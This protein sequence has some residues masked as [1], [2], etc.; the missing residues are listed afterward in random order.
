M[1]STAGAFFN[2]WFIHFKILLDVSSLKFYVS[3]QTVLSGDVY[4]NFTF[5]VDMMDVSLELL[6]RWK[7]TEPSS[8]LARWVIKYL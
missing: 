5:L 8:S 2:I 3:F 7:P 4:T 1:H 6:D